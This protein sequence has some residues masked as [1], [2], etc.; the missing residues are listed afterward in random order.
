MAS[1]WSTST[2]VCDP[3]QGVTQSLVVGTPDF[4]EN[5]VLANTS[6]ADLSLRKP[7]PQYPGSPMT[8]VE[9]PGK[10]EPRVS[11]VPPRMRAGRTKSLGPCFGTLFW[12]LW[13]EN[14][15]WHGDRTQMGVFESLFMRPEGAVC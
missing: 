4:Q 6:M 8:S 1:H 15:G 2:Q 5:I 11:L 3:V 9:R 10:L 7:L 14:S 12:V 13:R